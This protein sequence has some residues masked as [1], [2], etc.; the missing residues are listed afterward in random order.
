MSNI[1]DMLEG[2]VEV[3]FWAYWLKPM[4]SSFTMMKTGWIYR[5]IKTQEWPAGSMK[6]I[7][8]IPMIT[9]RYIKKESIRG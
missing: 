5:Q 2:A 6:Y 1:D 7:P 9:R 8:G 4:W 3:G